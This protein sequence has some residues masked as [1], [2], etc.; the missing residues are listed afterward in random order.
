[1]KIEVENTF[2]GGV[3][4]AAWLF[5]IGYVHLPFWKVVLAIVFWPYFLGK[6]L[7]LTH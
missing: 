5:P 6:A 2:T 1:M 3:W 7:A 4:L